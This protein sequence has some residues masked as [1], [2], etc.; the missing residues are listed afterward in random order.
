MAVKRLTLKDSEKKVTGLCAGIAEYL[1]VDVT[2][3]RLIV[4]TLIIMSGVLP[5]LLAY[6]IA[7]AITPREGEVK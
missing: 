1:E 2:V 5:G 4:L 3:I 6:L 7:S